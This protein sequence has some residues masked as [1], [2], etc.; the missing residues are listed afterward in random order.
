MQSLRRQMG[1]DARVLMSSVPYEYY[2][3]ACFMKPFA[4]TGF[5]LSVF[6]FGYQRLVPENI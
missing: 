5:S 3:S 1:N 6:T 4:Y 2:K